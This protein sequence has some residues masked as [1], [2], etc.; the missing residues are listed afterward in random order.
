M[1]V[2]IMCMRIAMFSSLDAAHSGVRTHR[3]ATDYD[4]TTG[5]FLPPL[6]GF[7]VLV[8][9]QYEHIYNEFI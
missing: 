9:K 2:L 6:C 7:V 1:H 8:Q 4:H 5:K 3:A